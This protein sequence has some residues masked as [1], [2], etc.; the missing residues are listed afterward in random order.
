[1]RAGWSAIPHRPQAPETVRGT[2]GMPALNQ[3]SFT[4]VFGNQAVL[5]RLERLG[6][7]TRVFANLVQ[8]GFPARQLIDA[9]QWYSESA[10][11][12]VEHYARRNM[13]RGFFEDESLLK[14]FCRYFECT[15]WKLENSPWFFS[16]DEYD[17]FYTALIDPVE[18]QIAQL[19]QGLGEDRWGGYF[20]KLPFDLGMS[21][22]KMALWD[23]ICHHDYYWKP[24]DTYGHLRAEGMFGYLR[25]TF[26]ILHF[27]PSR[28]NY[29]WE[30]AF[31]DRFQRTL[32]RFEQKLEES[33]R[34]WQELRREGRNQRFQYRSYTAGSGVPLYQEPA[35]AFSFLGLD[36]A[37]ATVKRVR[38]EFRRLSKETHPDHGGSREAF[39]RLSRYKEIAEAWLTRSD[40]C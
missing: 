17:R 8:A 23:D 19:E 31:R 4:R 6:R 24:L 10:G 22:A 18:F 14:L 40:S 33:A 26:D 5:Y 35:L 25:R 28:F 3:Q 9:C 2:V 13:A 29:N 1:M 12:P 32:R 30:R 15:D 16:Q 38:R 20:L 37:T 21:Q 11:T 39:Q 27:S 7:S 36:P 34:L